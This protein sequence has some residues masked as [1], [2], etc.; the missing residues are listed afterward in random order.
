M[1]FSW[2]RRLDATRLGCTVG[3][4]ERAWL[5]PKRLANVLI[6][7]S[8]AVQPLLGTVIDA[9]NAWQGEQTGESHRQL[10]I[11][12]VGVARL[13]VVEPLMLVVIIQER[14]EETCRLA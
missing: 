14:Y 6:A 7:V 11:E 1:N 3:V 2:T 12:T 13:A 5:S 10:I 9:G 4:G 8:V